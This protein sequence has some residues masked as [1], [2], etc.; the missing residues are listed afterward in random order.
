[1][2]VLFSWVRAT[3]PRYRWDQLMVLTWRIFL[4]LV[5]CSVTLLFL[6]INF[7]LSQDI[8]YV[9]RLPLD[10]QEQFRMAFG[11]NPEYETLLAIY[12]LLLERRGLL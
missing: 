9:S 7:S 5:L 4:P 11:D 1:M 6:V 3:L 8:Y 10:L 2:L 12:E